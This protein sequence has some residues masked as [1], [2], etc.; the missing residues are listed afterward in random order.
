MG[1]QAFKGQEDQMSRYY[2]IWTRFRG[3]DVY[4]VY[5]TGNSEKKALR[6]FKTRE[7]ALRYIERMEARD[8]LQASIRKLK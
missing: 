3:D 1:S 4:E 5:C 6:R 8:R 2:I 7:A